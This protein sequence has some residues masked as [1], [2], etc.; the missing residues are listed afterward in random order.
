MVWEPMVWERVRAVG[1]ALFALLVVLSW[2]P[3]D[4]GSSDSSI[5]I[6]G[7]RHIASGDGYVGC[8][9]AL[10]SR[11][12][13]PITTFAPGFSALLTPGL[14]LGM[15]AVGSARVVLTVSFVVAALLVAAMSRAVYG[16]RAAWVPMLAVALFVLQPSQ[17][18]LVNRVLSDVPFVPLVLGT[19]YLALLMSRKS[20]P[21]WHYKVALGAL[22]A[23]VALL[24]NAGLMVV[25][26]ILLGVFVSMR[27]PFSF[28][29]RALQMAPVVATFGVLYAPW[30]IRNSLVAAKPLGR[31]AL[32]VTNPVKHTMD[33]VEGAFAWIPDATQAL[34]QWKLSG[35]VWVAPVLALVAVTVWAA[36]RHGRWKSPAIRLLASVIVGYFLLMVFTAT[37]HPFNP[38]AR[39]RFWSPVW[40]LTGLLL[41]AILRRV[42]RPVWLRRAW[43]GASSVTAVV[44]GLAFVVSLPAA[45]RPEGLLE[46]R[47]AE[48]TRLLPKPGHCRLLASNMTPFL[49]H[50]HLGLVSPFP[51]AVKDWYKALGRR[52]PICVAVL[53]QDLERR[54]DEPPRVSR[55][56]WKEL[57]KLVKN[58]TLTET[59]RHDELRIYERERSVRRKQER[60]ARR[61]RGKAASGP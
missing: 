30:L 19:V 41:L 52:G 44:Y 8:R 35:A 27:G 2:G 46:P 43:L 55:P 56:V 25:P 13:G 17:L 7:A 32:K 58:K 48:L 31:V 24:R 1:V 53:T 9:T 5:Y 23:G 15:S 38:L 45:R 12:F 49:I 39:V 11:K 61:K 10:D 54:G 42:R 16:S 21:S 59:V 33:A 50:R 47:F 18:Y 26:G 4:A 22:L 40:P 28:R 51:R 34:G 60:P 29:R 20:R 57:R 36:G 6:D 3:G 14:W 37:V